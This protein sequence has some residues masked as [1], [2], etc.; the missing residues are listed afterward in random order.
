[1]KAEI[2]EVIDGKVVITNSIEHPY[3]LRIVIDNEKSFDISISNQ[4][5]WIDI[6]GDYLLEIQPVAA[7]CIRLKNKN[8]FE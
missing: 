8:S 6:R 7:N 3:S 1:M 4:K 2:L 5:G